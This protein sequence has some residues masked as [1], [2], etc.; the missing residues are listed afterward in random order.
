M[1]DRPRPHWS[2][3]AI[4]QYL[5]CPLQY[6]FQRVLSL[7]S[8]TIGTGLVMGS[9][10]H[11]GLAEYHRRLLMKE[12]LDGSI[13]R[14][15]FLECWNEKSR[16]QKILYRDGETQ[17][18]CIAQGVQLLD[19]YL[20]EPPPENI[21]SIEQRMLVPL[22]N[23]QGEYLERPLL[24]FTDLVTEANQ[25]LTVTEFKTSARAYS[26]SDVESSLQPTCYVHAVRESL[27][28][29]A[30][31]EYTVLVKTKTPKVQKLKTSRFP[32]DSGRLGDLVQAVERAVEL[33]VFYPVENSMN[34]SGC[35]Y[36][37]QCREWGQRTQQSPNLPILTNQSEMACSPN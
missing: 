16:N 18:D 23:S 33:E 1:M 9:A 14:K 31:V 29:E 34:C 30:N 11:A 35:S 13:I 19:L 25:E 7:P 32:E 6:Y 37:Q 4:T 21:V 24:A 36:R 12:N 20:Q 26:A 28:R 2:Y 5:R 27:G 17:N 3:S 15:T 10:V 22:C 8:Q